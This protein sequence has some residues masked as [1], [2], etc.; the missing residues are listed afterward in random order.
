MRI[1]DQYFRTYPEL[2]QVVVNLKSGTA[3]EGLFWKHI[4]RYVV[5]KQA[6]VIQDRGKNLHKSADGEIIVRAADIDFMQVTD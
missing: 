2:R 1:L 3:F 4:G 6:T 5:I